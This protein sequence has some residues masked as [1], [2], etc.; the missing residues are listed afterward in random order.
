MELGCDV[1]DKGQGWAGLP[2]EWDQQSLLAALGSGV[3]FSQEYVERDD[4]A[5]GPASN[6]AAAAGMLGRVIASSS[7]ADKLL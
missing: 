1:L 2:A 4:G 7:W 6:P 5:V 3:C